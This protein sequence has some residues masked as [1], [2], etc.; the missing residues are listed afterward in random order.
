MIRTI[1]F[2][3]GGSHGPPR[4]FIFRVRVPRAGEATRPTCDKPFVHVAFGTP[5]S[6]GGKGVSRG[7]RDLAHRLTRSAGPPGIAFDVEADVDSPND[8][9]EVEIAVPRREVFSGT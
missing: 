4:V 5:G 1:H 6:S 2:K 7:K 8:L 9:V 3:R